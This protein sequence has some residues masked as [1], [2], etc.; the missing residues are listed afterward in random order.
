MENRQYN[1][2]QNQSGGM[3]AR[4]S[5]TDAIR[6]E[7]VKVLRNTYTLLAMTL[8][9]SAVMAAV[10]MS[11]GLGRGASLVCSLGALAASLAVA[12]GGGRCAFD[13]QRASVF[14]VAPA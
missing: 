8:L 3:I 4:G 10:S 7:A 14:V 1:Y 13:S 2:S 9:F 12:V 11:V 5:A 6:P